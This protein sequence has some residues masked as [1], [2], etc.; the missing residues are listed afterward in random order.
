MTSFENNQSRALQAFKSSVKDELQALLSGEVY[1]VEEQA[2]TTSIA[3][4]LDQGATSD[5]LISLR[6]QGLLY[7]AASR[8]RFIK[9]TDELNFDFSIQLRNSYNGSCHNTELN[10]LH[11]L[12]SAY[13]SGVPVILP[14]YLCFSR[15]EDIKG[16]FT[17]H[18]LVA[19]ETIPLIKIVFAPHGLN[20]PNLRQRYDSRAENSKSILIRDDKKN[21]G[22]IQSGTDNSFLFLNRRVLDD[23]AIPY[24]LADKRATTRK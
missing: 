18:D 24:L 13:E 7:T 22:G 1:S 16:T 4:L 21:Y 20:L 15:V 12:V 5:L 8:I 14:R 3:A 6:S 11:R 19:V 23:Y 9:S 10:K 17:L 2:S